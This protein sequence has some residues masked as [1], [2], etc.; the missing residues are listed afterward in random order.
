[1]ADPMALVLAAAAL[2][3]VEFVGMP[4]ARIPLSQAAIYVAKAPK[5]NAAYRAIE[6]AMK[7][8]ADEE[9]QEV[10]DHLKDASYSGAKELGHGEGYVYPHSDPEGAKDQKYTRKKKK[11][12]EE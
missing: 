5:S 1:M 6:A 3:A 4:E 10:P 9:T 8:V 11:Y 7:D 12:Y 2:R